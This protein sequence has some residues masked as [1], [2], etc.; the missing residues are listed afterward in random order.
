MDKKKYISEIPELMKEW[1]WEANTKLGLDPSKITIGSEK[2]V[3]WLCKKGHRWIANIYNRTKGRG[4]PICSNKKVLKGYNDLETI[5]PKLAQEWN[6]EKN[7]PL[8]PTQVTGKSN[9]KVWWK[10]VKGHEWQATVSHRSSGQKCPICSNKKVLKGYNDLE[11]VNPKLAREWNYNKNHPLLPTQITC[12]SSKKVWWK[13]VKGHEWQATVSSRNSGMNCPVCSNQKILIGYNDLA[14]TNPELVKEWNYEK[15]APF[16]PTQVFEKSHKKVWWKCKKGHEW[17]ASLAHRSYGENCPKCSQEQK[18]SFAEQAIFYYLSKYFKNVQNRYLIDKTECDIFLKDYNCSVEYDGQFFHTNSNKDIRKIKKLNSLGISTI[19]IREPNCPD[20]TVEKAYIYKLKNLT[21]NELERAINF[22]FSKIDKEIVP[23]IDIEKDRIKILENS[24]TIEKER[25]LANL[26]PELTKEWN[27]KKNGD[28]KPDFFSVGSH[29]KIWW[30]C[31]QGHEYQATIKDRA[32]GRGC[33]ICSNKKV[34]KG[35]NDLETINPK[36]AQE[37]N[38]DKNYPLLP[39]QITSGS[40][41][42]V[43]WKCKKGHEWQATIS[44]RNL[45]EQCPVCTGKKTQ[46]GEN[47]I[48]TICPN[49]KDEW[50]YEKNIGLN[51]LNFPKGSHTKVWW[52][53]SKCGHEWQA[54]VRQ[55]VKGLG[56]C[57]ICSKKKKK[58][59]NQFEFDF[60]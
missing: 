26:N 54:E 34:L 18:T 21:T 16:L 47:D 1:D 32:N 9:K 7:Y 6:Y 48:F 20:I 14:T 58:N 38:Y 45:G 39:T 35:Y 15:N 46:I 59:K 57:P 25:S 12:G 4:C 5:N 11:T 31:T 36:L 40:Q 27:Y 33:P 56:K 60:K 53:C 24:F 17:Q 28:L 44:H 29:H 42:K 37:W 41:K 30:R 2:K 13:C 43:W 10:C 49:L 3:C 23:L 52:K 50:N 55:R 19:N 8:S 51:P 22:I